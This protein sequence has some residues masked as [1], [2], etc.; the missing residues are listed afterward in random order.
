MTSHF[1]VLSVFSALVSIAFALLMRREP[2][3][4]VRF[5]VFVF[6]CFVVSAFALGWL[7]F[8]FPT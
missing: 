1:L 5:G 8:P 7:M 6:V 2:A 3:E 4:Q